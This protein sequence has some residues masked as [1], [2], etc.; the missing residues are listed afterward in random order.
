M[1]GVYNVIEDVWREVRIRR[2]GSGRQKASGS[3][4][5]SHSLRRPSVYLNG[6]LC[7]PHMIP[8]D[9]HWILRP[10]KLSPSLSPATG[11]R[12]N[13]SI[14]SSHLSEGT[15]PLDELSV[16]VRIGPEGSQGQTAAYQYSLL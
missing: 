4:P 9:T 2:Y 15:R 8:L 1:Q 11:T 6:W 14:I 13:P 5:S 16:T 10:G 12:P 3:A 7:P